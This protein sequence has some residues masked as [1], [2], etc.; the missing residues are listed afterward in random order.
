MP[1]RS[2]SIVASASGPA[3]SARRAT[4][5]PGATGSMRPR[6]DDEAARRQEHVAG[7]VPSRRTSSGTSSAGIAAGSRGR[8]SR[9]GLDRAAV[10]QRP[11]LDVAH[12]LGARGRRRLTL[13][14]PHAIGDEREVGVDVDRR[15][16]AR[17]RRRRGGT[18][19]VS[20]RRRWTPSVRPRL[21]LDRGAD[22]RAAEPDREVAGLV[23]G[24]LGGRVR[25]QGVRV[26]AP[27]Q[28]DRRQDNRAQ[29]PTYAHENDRSE[30]CAAGRKLGP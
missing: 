26:R 19:C 28:A 5:R 7:E 17:P 25:R 10:R 9:A 6:A 1:S 15:R 22:P 18:A 4:S 23:G 16:R 8:S 12:G 3:S 2:R 21:G 13:G 27:T 29:K 11:P 30:L 14:P 24:Q 20:T